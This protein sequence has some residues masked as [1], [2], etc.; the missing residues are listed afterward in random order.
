M[1]IPIPLKWYKFKWYK[2]NFVW[3][4]IQHS[5][6]DIQWWPHRL[7]CVPSSTGI[8]SSLLMCE[9]YHK[10]MGIS[11]FVSSF[12]TNH[13]IIPPV[14]SMG[15]LVPYWYVAFFKLQ[16]ISL[17]RKTPKFQSSKTWDH[18]HLDQYPWQLEPNT[19]PKRTCQ[20]IF[21]G[22]CHLVGGWTNPFEKY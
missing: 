10:F 13:H 18:A 2:W 6:P 3:I 20:R 1:R 9:M 4:V 15:F 17:G 16:M 8:L 7:D 19:W 12:D 22:T 21:S 14:Q 11:E 5:T